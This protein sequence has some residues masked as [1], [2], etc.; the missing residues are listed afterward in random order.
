MSL[1]KKVLFAT[2]IIIVTIVLINF[3]QIKDF[4]SL[5]NLK[6]NGNLLHDYVEN[7][8]GSSVLIF[9]CISIVIMI[10]GIP[11]VGVISVAGGFLFDTLLGSIYSDIGITIGAIISFLGAKHLFGHWVQYKYRDKLQKF[12]R[13]IRR[14]GNRYFLIIRFILVIPS[15]VVNILA[16]ASKVS[17]FT[18]AWTTFVGLLPEIFIYAYAGN[19]LGDINSIDEI[20]SFEIICT[21]VLIALIMLIPNL[22]YWKKR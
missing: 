12:N 3:S 16:G 18:F 9:L 11:A 21:F 20:F 1:K 17:T 14:S 22:I 7:N 4:F 10:F 5:K 6:I 15:F 2:L 19:K 13:H 8:Y